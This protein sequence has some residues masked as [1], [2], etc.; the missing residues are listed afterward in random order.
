MYY[1]SILGIE[2]DVEFDLNELN[3]EKINFQEYQ[4]LVKPQYSRR[5]DDNNFFELGKC[6]CL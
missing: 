4:Y 3:P 2:Y 1:A 5:V 6:K